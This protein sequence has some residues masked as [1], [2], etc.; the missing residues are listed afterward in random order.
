MVDRTEQPPADEPTS[1][2]VTETDRDKHPTDTATRVHRGSRFRRRPVLQSLAGTGLAA[3]A[4]VAPVAASE[5]ASDQTETSS[6]TDGD[7]GT[8]ATAEPELVAD[9][10]PP[11]LPE[12]LALDDSGTV[13]LSLAVTGELLAVDPDGNQES[14]AQFDVGE[15]GSLL[16]IVAID[17]TI[18]A[19]V[20][21][22]D[23]ETHGVWTVDIASGDTERMAEL[24]AEETAPNGITVDPYTQDGFLVTDHLGGAI[25]R[26]TPDDATVWVDDELLDPDPE[27]EGGV[28]AD[29]IAINPD[30]DVYVDNLDYGRLVRVP[31][32]EDGSSG[33][34]DLVAEEDSLV[35]ADGMT[36]DS[37]GRLYVAVNARDAIVRVELGSE[38]DGSESVAIEES[39]SMETEGNRSMEGGDTESVENESVENE[40]TERADNESMETEG[41]PTEAEDNESVAADSTGSTATESASEQAGS[42]S[43]ETLAEGGLLDFPA[44]VAFGRTAGDETFLYACN[45]AIGRFEAEAET[46]EPS[47]VRLDVGATGAFFGPNELVA[48]GET[49]DGEAASESADDAEVGDA[50]DDGG[51]DARTDGSNETGGDNGNENGNGNNGETEDY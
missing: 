4:G 37:Q 43:I 15:E 22:G 44:D 29:G 50:A 2:P 8:D 7:T 28:G 49:A 42:P 40:S 18:Y 20:N 19:L 31:V 10:E 45:F 46:A 51:T 13:Y 27:A 21:S 47:L 25:W 16:G 9:L 34:L 6:D 33:E 1:E 17:G 39:G 38:M 11:A 5:T 48:A 35:G 3:I 23:P 24:P 30:G 32:S 26:V 14:V 41:G 36:F 12:N